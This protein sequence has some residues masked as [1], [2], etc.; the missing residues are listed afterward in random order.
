MTTPDPMTREELLEL[1]ALDVFGMLDEYE[2]ALFTRSFHHAPS[3]VQD[4]ITE[5]QAT[6]AVDRSFLPQVEPES[7]LR[8]RVL[9]N[10]AREIETED[11]PLAL[12]GRF[13]RGAD[14]TQQDSTQQY[15]R[16]PN[17]GTHFWR[18]AAL[19]LAA[20][21]I[22]FAYFIMDSSEH[23]TGIAVAVIEGDNW[24][25]V[26]T[27][28]GGDFIQDFVSNPRAK[29]ISLSSPTGNPAA[30][31]MLYV[32]ERTDHPGTYD[33]ALRTEGLSEETTYSLRAI[34][35]KTGTVMKLD[36]SFKTAVNAMSG[37]RLAKAVTTV[38]SSATAL[39]WEIINANDDV[40][41][42]SA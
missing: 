11:K 27:Q 18:A 20:G 21:N 25:E 40:V 12:I 37:H 28:L 2:T 10:I 29:K 4:E 39:T 6:Y 30:V 42:S 16:T 14:S 38:G 9:D 1:A 35:K 5:L 32:K 13:N 7:G 24:A 17:V 22:V 36:W 33:L 34:D 31:A 19:L 26:R 23:Y 8:P 15:S 41:L 3:A